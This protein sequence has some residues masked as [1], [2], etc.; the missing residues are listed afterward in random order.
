[1]NSSGPETGPAS[2]DNDIYFPSSKSDS[3]RTT[4]D[5]PTSSSEVYNY[6]TLAYSG[7]TLPRN[8]KKVKKKTKKEQES[9]FSFQ[10]FVASVQGLSLPAGDNGSARFQPRV[11]IHWVPWTEAPGIFI[12][13]LTFKVVLC[14]P[15]SG[16]SH[17][18]LR[19]A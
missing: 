6:R 19:P 5:L 17:R 15:R 18:A 9:A 1:M 8:F 7:G 11:L 13:T 14:F 10:D 16:C 2:Q 3:C 12:Q 4:A